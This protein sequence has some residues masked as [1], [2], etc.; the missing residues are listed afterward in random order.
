MPSFDIVSQVDLQEVRNAVDQAAREV[1]TRYDFK[2]TD[3]TVRLTDDG[4]VVESA[5]E[6]RLDAAVDVLKG[7]LVRR[8]VSLKSVSGGEPTQVGGGR[9]RA[10]FTLNQGIDQDAAKELAKLIRDSKVKVQA[11]IQGDRL[12]VQGKKRDDLQTVIAMLRDLDFR[13]P[14]Q[15][16]NQRD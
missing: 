15:Y 10:T 9:S 11:Q 2:G 13:L 3:T 5:T 7:R 16:V 4:I 8:K 1:A 14:L 12:R 6:D